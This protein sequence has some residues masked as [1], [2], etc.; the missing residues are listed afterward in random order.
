[1][2]TLYPII[3]HA[4]VREQGYKW[5][6]IVAANCVRGVRG[7]DDATSVFSDV[8]GALLTQR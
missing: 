1:M 7:G 2:R 8:T 4:D 6:D 3:I 5:I